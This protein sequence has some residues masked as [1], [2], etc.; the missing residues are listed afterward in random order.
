MHYGR[1]GG[2]LIPSFFFLDNGVFS[3]HLLM[4]GEYL[5]PRCVG[6]IDG[7]EMLICGEVT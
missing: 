7:G 4:N 6:D 1:N 2:F 5:K 3:S